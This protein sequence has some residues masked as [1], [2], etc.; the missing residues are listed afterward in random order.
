MGG[1]FVVAPLLL[2][3]GV[4]I[5]EMITTNFSVTEKDVNSARGSEPAR[6]VRTTKRFAHVTSLE[7]KAL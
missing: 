1:L 3:L 4:F 7:R 6:S 5:A 2:P